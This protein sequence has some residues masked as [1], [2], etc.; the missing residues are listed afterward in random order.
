MA[1][2]ETPRLEGASRD[3]SSE[4]FLAFLDRRKEKSLLPREGRTSR[5]LARARARAGERRCARLGAIYRPSVSIAGVAH[6]RVSNF[7][8]DKRPRAVSRGLRG[9]RRVRAARRPATPMRGCSA[10]ID[11]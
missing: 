9:G 6:D 11:M 5:S 8:P 3:S 10:L 7:H 1:R 4:P 2:E